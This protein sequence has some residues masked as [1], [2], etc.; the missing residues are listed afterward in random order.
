[1]RNIIVLSLLGFFLLFYS[2]NSTYTSK[3][4]AGVYVN[5]YNDNL[6]D[7]SVPHEAPARIDTLTL[8]EDYTFT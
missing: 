1:M 6:S 7:L 2:C 4:L 3:D 5:N 8:F